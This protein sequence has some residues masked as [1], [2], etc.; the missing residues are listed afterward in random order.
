MAQPPLMGPSGLPIEEALP[1]LRAALASRSNVVLQAPPG[2]GKSTV[3]PLALL[4]EPWARGRRLVMLEPRRL[5][6]RAVADR[7]AATLRESVGRTVGLR[8]RLSTR[9]SRATR[10]EVVTEGVLTRMLQADPALEGICLVLFDEF[11]ERSAQGDLGLAL[12]LDAQAAVA[13]Q[14]KLL[15]MSATLDAGAIAEWLGSGPPVTAAGRAY[16]VE[17]RYVGKAAPPLEGA[18]PGREAP[19]EGA[20][21]REVTQA[22]LD[23][24]GDV[25][26]FL[27]G[28]PEIRRVQVLLGGGRLD[29]S[30]RVLPLH[31]VLAPSDQQA[32]L[33]PAAQG[34]RKVILSTN[35][36]ETSLTVEGV[37][38][39]IDC[40]LVR[41]AVLDPAS[42]MSRLETRRIS[43]ASADQR[44][45][46]AGR[47][48]PGV[49]YRLWSEEAQRSLAAHTPPEILE[50]DLAS[51]ALELAA[52]GVRDARE[53]RWIDPPPEATLA[54]ARDLLRKL[55]AFDE[56]G[57]LSAHGREMARIAAH[58]RLAHMLL[59]GRR[60]GRLALAADLAALLSERD[61]LRGRGAPDDADIRTRLE[62]LRGA[63]AS[64]EALHRI[65]RVAQAFVQQLGSTD[66]APV[67]RAAAR[68]RNAASGR[69]LRDAGLLL[70]FA[71]PDRIGL[72]RAPVQA[73]S[74]TGYL[75]ANGR[76][77]SFAGAQSLAREEL[78]VA[79]DLD[80]RER[81]AR[82]R[83]A[84]PLARAELEQHFGAAVEVTR[85]I[86]WSERERAVAATETARLGALILGVKS[87]EPIPDEARRAAMLEGVRRMGLD[88][89][90]WT[91]ELR[92]WQARVALVRALPA[93][94][95]GGSNERPSRA[96][97][98]P[99]W[100]DA[101]DIALL[102]SLDH[103]L[104]PWLEGVARAEHLNRVPLR[105]ALQALLTHEQRVRLDALAPT[106][107][108]VPSGSRIRIDYLD[109][110]APVAAVRLQ[111]V[112]GL[113]QTPRIGGG[114]LP[115]TF[116]LLSPAQRP[117][118][119]TRD[120]ASF[121]RTGYAEVRKDLRGRYPK[122]DWPEN[123]LEAVPTRR[124]RPPRA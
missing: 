109:D 4:D 59:E 29:P 82:I 77:A 118:Q 122:H 25:L 89:L 58:P 98:G 101:S 2:A 72:R 66:P 64:R 36:A 73:V 97:G 70:A 46:R 91:P 31:G 41:R 17:T 100:P 42:G 114:T 86:E 124:V 119:I 62:A 107:L 35:I 105:D 92:G 110:S 9:V 61:P 57:R 43:R 93:Q 7:M 120:L 88:S 71:Y 11:H 3:V 48:A 96:G 75:L 85:A 103:W 87:L 76:G 104:A 63:A 117:V 50:A 115:V 52:W 28:A 74:G 20:V 84:A 83:L 123:P 113:T 1:A 65:R 22:L 67:G 95:S 47:L 32:A 34:T 121:W 54:S 116:K 30:I 18:Q 12:A 13:P 55:G 94:R 108:R 23:A 15:L 56:T 53:L 112:F 78:I 45:G 21:A 106:H 10:I 27:P 51:V 6:A 49:C 99:P 79:V 33:V 40:G 38:V 37:R 68:E 14:L 19:L 111:E 8:M 80:D 44:Q 16:P 69:D 81:E 90:P 102:A 26:V 39:V 24:P 60:L 5:A